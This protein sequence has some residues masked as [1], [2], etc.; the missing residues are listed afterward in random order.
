MG[1]VHNGLGTKNT[2]PCFNVEARSAIK[3]SRSQDQ[4]KLYIELYWC[5][6]SSENVVKT[7]VTNT[8]LLMYMVGEGHHV[9]RS[10]V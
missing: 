5:R 8:C 2:T 10:K 1:A 6:D 3:P 4:A 9:Q 7:A